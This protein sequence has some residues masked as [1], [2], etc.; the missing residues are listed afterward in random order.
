MGKSSEIL[1]E[2]LVEPFQSEE[3]FENFCLKGLAGLVKSLLTFAVLSK[4]NRHFIIKLILV[5]LLSVQIKGASEFELKLL[6]LETFCFWLSQQINSSMFVILIFSCFYTHEKSSH[7]MHVLNLRS[8][9]SFVLRSVLGISDNIFI[10]SC[11]LSVLICYLQKDNQKTIL[12]LMLCVAL[13]LCGF[14]MYRPLS[15]TSSILFDVFILSCTW[16]SLKF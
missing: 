1:S 11:I 10:I 12:D 9:I 14:L 16:M 4:E 5:C 3:D 13:A 8:F 15:Y 7:L 6:F 2:I